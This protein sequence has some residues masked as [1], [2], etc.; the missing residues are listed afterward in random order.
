M[1][2]RET[3]PWNAVTLPEIMAG[4]VQ[5]GKLNAPVPFYEGRAA[6]Q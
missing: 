6:G 2:Q 1:V 4:A 5:E 3:G